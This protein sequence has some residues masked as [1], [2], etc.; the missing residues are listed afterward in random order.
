MLLR[1]MGAGIGSESAGAAAAGAATAMTATAARA[2][3]LGTRRGLP[4]L[5]RAETRVVDSRFHGTR[6]REGFISDRTFP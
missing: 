4:L 3:D 5:R 2:M 6:A 1:G